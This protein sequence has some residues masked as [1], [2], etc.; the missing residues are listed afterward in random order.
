MADFGTL[1]RKFRLACKDPLY[2]ERR[3]SQ[4]R[5][6]E[7][8]GEE[9]DMKAGYSG[10]AISDWERGKSKINADQRL[11]LISLT[12]VLK[13]LGGLKN[14]REA[15][16][17]LE[18]GN[19]RALNV[20][21]KQ[22]IFPAESNNLADA[23]VDKE[24]HRQQNFRH[25]LEETSNKFVQEL[26]KIIVEAQVGPPPAWPRVVAPLIR[27][28][29]EYLAKSNL[30]LASF[31][32]WTWLLTWLLIAPSLRLPFT[33][34]AEAEFAL[35][36]Y[37]AGSIIAPLLVG[38]L[39]STKKNKFW[40]E[41]NLASHYVTRLYTYQGA[42]I[43][44]HL[45]YFGIFAIHLLGY[46][47]H[48]RFTVWLELIEMGIILLW[49]Y[50]SACLVPYNLWRAYG[51]LD[52]SDGRIFFI[53]L[54]LG[55]FWAFFFFQLS[56]MFFNSITGS[57]IIFFSITLLIFITAWQQYRNRSRQ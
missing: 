27:K 1:L 45:G 18:A 7:L 43:G 56:P 23:S 5:L 49:G 15:N 51:R 55:P 26:H 10:A 38:V 2:P 8:L 37:L 28:C 42:G 11:V 50:F 35:K 53:F 24:D 36:L 34:H 40:L 52:L 47:L 48:L 6:G 17:L 20:D 13:Q 3:L 33:S 31:W 25:P 16:E 4:E 22:K 30:V 19:Y 12:K 39:T 57:L 21:E 54:I 32:F 29:M 14:S 44:F 46:Y 9:L 41:H